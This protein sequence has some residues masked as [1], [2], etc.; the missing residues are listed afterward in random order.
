MRRT[1][2]LA[3]MAAALGVSGVASA[4]NSGSSVDATPTNFTF[5]GGLVFPMDSGLRD[6]A[7]LW[8]GVGVDYLFPTQLIRG[9]SQ[10]YLSADWF[11][12]GTGGGRGNVWPIALNQRFYAGQGIY[13]RE[14]R[15][16]FFVGAGVAILDFSKSSTKFLMRGGVGTELGPNIIAEATLTLTDKD[17]STGIRG[18]AIGVYLGYRF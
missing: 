9:G 11:I 1:I 14:F 18:N 15:N 7:D 17:N 12:R 4:Q 6:V 8:G 16:Y 5:R 10:T 13:N 3:A 2:L